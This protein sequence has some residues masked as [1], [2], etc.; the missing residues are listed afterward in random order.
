MK[1]KLALIGFSE[2]ST[3][4]SDFGL[5]E[6]LGILFGQ[7]GLG[8]SAMKFMGAKLIRNRGR[9]SQVGAIV[10]AKPEKAVA[11]LSQGAAG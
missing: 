2:A 10:L 8:V 7:F 4:N 5:G 1:G 3:F 11:R 6:I 9:G